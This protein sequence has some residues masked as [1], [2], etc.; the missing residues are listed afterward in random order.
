[1]SEKIKITHIIF[2]DDD[3]DTDAWPVGE[4]S[5]L[6]EEVENFFSEYGR[7]ECFVVEIKALK[8][9]KRGKICFEEIK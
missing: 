9:A 2:A 4:G 6:E 1:M 3:L 5:D 8:K 7:E